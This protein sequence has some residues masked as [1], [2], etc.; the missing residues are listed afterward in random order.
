VLAISAFRA[1]LDK[2][3]Q[4]RMWQK[5]AFLAVMLLVGAMTPIAE[6]SRAIIFPVWPINFQAT[7]IGADCGGYAPHYVAELGGQIITHVLREPYRL[8]LG[9]LG[10]E[11]CYNP[12]MEIMGRRYPP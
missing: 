5:K 10:P 6:L 2:S 7:L 11:S 8:A 3:Q 4:P 9:P 1:L 12:A